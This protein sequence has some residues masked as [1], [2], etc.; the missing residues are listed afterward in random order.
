MH[1]T[2]IYKTGRYNKVFLKA[3]LGQYC[4]GNT[5]MAALGVFFFWLMPVIFPMFSQVLGNLLK[6]VM[7]LAYLP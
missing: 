1:S 3:M 2:G 6:Q 7:T 4:F 5:Y